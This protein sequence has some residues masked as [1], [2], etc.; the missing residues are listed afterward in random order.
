MEQTGRYEIERNLKQN[1]AKG[2]LRNEREQASPNG[3][4]PS[5]KQKPIAVIKTHMN[6]L[7]RGSPTHELKLLTFTNYLYLKKV[8]N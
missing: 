4:T 2:E 1:Y 5:Q 6:I 7:H 8:L 3:A